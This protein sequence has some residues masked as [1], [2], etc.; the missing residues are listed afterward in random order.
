M[1]TQIEE[2]NMNFYLEHDIKRGVEEHT[3]EIREDVLFCKK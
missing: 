3:Y 2:I 1:R